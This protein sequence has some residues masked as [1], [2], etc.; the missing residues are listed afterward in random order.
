[1]FKDATR[2]FFEL[3]FDVMKIN[4]RRTYDIALGLKTIFS[5]YRPQR[6]KVCIYKIGREIW[7]E[8]EPLMR[9]K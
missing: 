6:G 3:A 9:A 4:A 8:W 2:Y 5:F 7:W 1:M